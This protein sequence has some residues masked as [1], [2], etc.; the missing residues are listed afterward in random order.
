MAADCCVVL[1][2]CGDRERAHII[3]RALV[4][5]HLAACVNMLP[6]DS[7]YTWQARL[8]ETAEIL[9]L[10]KITRADYAEVEKAILAL[11]DYETPEIVALPIVE[12]SAGY[13]DWIEAVARRKAER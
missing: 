8:E 11:H 13:L 4:E 9:L 6:I 12:G 10:I 1:T 5:R 7:V 3:A 2:T